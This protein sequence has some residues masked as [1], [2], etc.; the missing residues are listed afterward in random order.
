MISDLKHHITLQKSVRTPDGGG[1][2]TETWQ[3]ADSTPDV[4]AAIVPLSGSEQLRFH[5]LESTV[6]HRITLRYRNDVTPAMRL[7]HGT[8]VYNI[9]AITDRGGLGIWLDI[10]AALRTPA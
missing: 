8:D 9:T 5:Q 7:V 4:Y 10:L 3:N 2:F 1:G 6:T